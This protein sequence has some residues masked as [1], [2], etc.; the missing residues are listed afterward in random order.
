MDTHVFAVH[1]LSAA[2][3]PGMVSARKGSVLFIASMTSFIGMPRVIA[4]TAAKSAYVGMVR[5]LA[6]DYSADGVRDN[7][8]APGWI[9][10]PL[11]DQALSGDD[12]RRAKVLG[13]TS[14]NRFAA[15]ADHLTRSRLLDR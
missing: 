10:T 5:A 7:A 13:R 8:I 14:M 2:V 12:P 11:L 4:Y 1:A 3:V 15:A 9:Q 6:A